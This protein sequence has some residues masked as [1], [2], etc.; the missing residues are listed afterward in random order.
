MYF[1][2]VILYFG[3]YLSHNFTTITYQAFPSDRKRQLSLRLPGS[4]VGRHRQVGLKICLLIL[5]W[6][7]ISYLFVSLLLRLQFLCNS[8]LILEQNCTSWASCTFNALF[9]V[10]QWT[11]HFG[12]NYVI[13][14]PGFTCF[15]NNFLIIFKRSITVM[16]MN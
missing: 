12:I 8:A 4:L 3:N 16:I 10:R 6:E 7:F 2:L 13:V 15:H 14:F 11:V 9:G 5:K 1:L